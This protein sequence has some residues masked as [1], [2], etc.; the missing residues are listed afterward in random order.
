MTMYFSKQ[1]LKVRSFLSLPTATPTLN[2]T[3]KSE[4]L[5]PLSKTQ[6]TEGLGKES[7]TGISA[8]PSDSKGYLYSVVNV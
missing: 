3:L 2:L 7:V 5:F 6:Q 1:F 4:P 8:I